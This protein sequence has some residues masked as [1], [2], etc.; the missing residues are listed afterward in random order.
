MLYLTLLAG[1]GI[2]LIGGDF[3]VRGAVSIAERLGISAWLALSDAVA[4]FGTAYPALN[5]PATAEEV[6]RAVR[7]VRD[8]I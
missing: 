8:G 3:F 6:W 1:L 4:A 7:R 2:L 5:A